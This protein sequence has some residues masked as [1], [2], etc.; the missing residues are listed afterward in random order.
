MSAFVD[1]NDKTLE[2]ASSGGPD[3]SIDEPAVKDVDGVAAFHANWVAG[4][5][6]QSNARG[7]AGCDYLENPV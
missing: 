2:P 5:N 1:S 7:A 4:V 3:A 6:R